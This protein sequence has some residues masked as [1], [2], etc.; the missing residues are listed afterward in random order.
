VVLV[1]TSVW[2][3]FLAGREPYAT[4]L[5]RLL[6]DDRVLRHDFVQGELL[7]GGGRGRT[8]L[9]VAYARIDRARTLAHAEVVAFV[10]ARRLRARGVGWV[11]VHLLASTVVER[12]TLWS[13]DRNLAELAGEL[14]VAFPPIQ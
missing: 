6:A 10:E 4:A 12:C 2:V 8:E 5:D 3:R 14:R 11:D 13:T 9:L 1:D 7:V